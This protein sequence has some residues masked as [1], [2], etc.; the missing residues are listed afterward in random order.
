[1]TAQPPQICNADLQRWA[2]RERRGQ[3]NLDD[4]TPSALE[5]GHG[6]VAG[7]APA[8]LTRLPVLRWWRPRRAASQ[9]VWSLRRNEVVR[10]REGSAVGC[11]RGTCVV[12]QARDPEDHVLEAGDVFQTARRGLALVWAL[13]EA[14]LEADAGPRHSAWSS[15]PSRTVL[16]LRT[17]RRRA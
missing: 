15:P 12:T 4:M 6:R 3:A 13:T 10:V 2:V 8:W 1:M 14:E 17:R 7:A 5:M 11:R 16:R 9:R